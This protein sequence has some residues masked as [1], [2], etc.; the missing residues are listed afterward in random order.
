M[1]EPVSASLTRDGKHSIKGGKVDIG[2][3]QRVIVIEKID[4]DIPVRKPQSTT[5]S[6][7]PD[8]GA[9]LSRSHQLSAVR[10]RTP[11]RR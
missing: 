1:R 8:Y 3:L 9:D 11:R 6:F 5:A 7:V 10:V 4:E 2:R